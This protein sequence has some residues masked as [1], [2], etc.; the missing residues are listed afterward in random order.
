MKGGFLMDKKNTVIRDEEKIKQGVRLILEG[1][2]EDVNRAGL[3]E[4][5]DRIAK[6][7]NELFAA[8][9]CTDDPIESKI[10]EVQNNNLVVERDITFY[11]M[12]EH[13]MLPFFGRAA[14]AYIPDGEVIGL[15]KLVRIVDFYARKLQLQERLT[16]E[17]ASAVSRKVKNKGVF[18]ILSAEHLCVSMRGISNPSSVTV[19][20]ASTGAF[21]SDKNLR[22]EATAL[23]RGIF[24]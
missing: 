5:P 1:I 11:S 17:I 20:M 18:V 23:F 6:M 14:I 13:H 22:D 12:C 15:S 19:S 16:N 4:T 2:G 8:V 7:Y 21:L 9:G 24:K 3:L 10:F